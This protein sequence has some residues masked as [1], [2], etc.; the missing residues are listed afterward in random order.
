MDAGTD[1]M[2]DAEV[3]CFVEALHEAERHSR[4]KVAYIGAVDLSHIGPEF[5]DPRP[6]DQVQR[7]RLGRFDQAMLDRMSAGDPRGWFD[8]AA[9][10]GNRWRVCGLAATYTLLQ[11]LGRVRGRV[12]R[13]DQAIDERGQ[14]CVS[15]ASAVFEDD[16][17]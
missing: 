2:E 14:G 6:V 17:E 13:Y 9:R 4:K 1:P 16:R 8:T 7:A 12:V 5:G 15:F 10:V 11:V 3:S